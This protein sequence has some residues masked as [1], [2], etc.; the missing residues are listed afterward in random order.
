MTRRGLQQIGGEEELLRLLSKARGFF[1]ADTR[2][3]TLDFIVL[4]GASQIYWDQQ[5]PNI[6]F[7]PI[8]T[9]F[10]YL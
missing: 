1:S 7:I 5:T 4:M 2:W 9:N 10:S 8:S 3:C 6:Y